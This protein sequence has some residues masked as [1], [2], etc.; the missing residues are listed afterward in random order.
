MV[1]RLKATK[2]FKQRINLYLKTFLYEN[3]RPDYYIKEK[4]YSIPL[5]MR[6]LDE[7]LILN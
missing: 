1:N 5:I 6:I 3:D 4:T 2:S 7:A